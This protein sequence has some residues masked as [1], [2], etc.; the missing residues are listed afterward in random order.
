[1][2]LE[3]Y[4]CIRPGTV[5]FFK[6][7]KPFFNCHIVTWMQRDIVLRLLPLIDPDGTVFPIKSIASIKSNDLKQV[8]YVV[9]EQTPNQWD[10]AIIDRLENVWDFS[11][12]SRMILLKTFAPMTGLVI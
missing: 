4:V 6:A 12:Q 10:F 2:G 3:F 5:Q 8:E 1:M 11:Q 9:N 7:L